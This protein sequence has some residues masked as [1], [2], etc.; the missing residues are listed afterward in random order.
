M[1][2][3]YDGQLITTILK[4]TF[5]LLGLDILKAFNFIVDLEKLELYPA[6]EN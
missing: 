4:V 6:G 2:I 5:G 3:S 1:K